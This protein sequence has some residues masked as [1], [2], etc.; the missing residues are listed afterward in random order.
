MQPDPTH[1]WF[2]NPRDG[3]R[4]R[5]LALPSPEAPG[6]FVLEYVYR[7]HSGEQAVAPHL[8]PRATETFEILAGRARYRLGGETREADAGERIVMPP[9]IPHVHPWSIGDAPLHVRQTGET[10]PADPRGIRAS[11]QAQ[12]TIFGLA[13]AGRVNAAGLPGLLQ[14]AVLVDE[15]MPATYLAGPPRLVQRVLFGL[16]GGLGR[17]AGYR[18]GYPAYGLVTAAG[19]RAPERPAAPRL[20]EE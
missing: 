19:V 3:Q 4:V 6:R 7:P 13:A 18:A 12:I 5:V 14:L 1:P 17:L 16:L 20:A 2:E 9:G 11:I 15:A 8:H 10:A